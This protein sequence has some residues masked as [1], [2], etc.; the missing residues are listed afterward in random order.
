M[1]RKTTVVLGMLGPTIPPEYGGP[2]EWPAIARQ[3]ETR[4]TTRRSASYRSIAGEYPDWT[5]AVSFA[6]AGR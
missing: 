5:P 6:A 4:V 3:I 1:T 2:V